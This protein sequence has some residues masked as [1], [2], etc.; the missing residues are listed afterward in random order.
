S[1]SRSTSACFVPVEAVAR[2]SPPKC[3]P[4]S[5]RG[6]CPG[7]YKGYHETR[8]DSA[9]RPV[10]GRPRSNSYHFTPER[11]IPRT[12]GAPCPLLGDGV[13]PYDRARTLFVRL[14]DRLRLFRT[15]T[16]DFS[17][18]ELLAGK[19]PSRQLSV[20]RSAQVAT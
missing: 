6:A 19:A 8:G 5:L 13:T 2:F 18:E 9:L 20:A 11:D 14:K 7:L 3:A 4:C 15:E 17:D 16:R 1:R 10:L 12:A